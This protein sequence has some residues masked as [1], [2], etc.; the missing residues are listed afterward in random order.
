ME[1]IIAIVVVVLGVA[2]YFNRK[3]TESTDPVETWT[4]PKELHVTAEPAP[5]PAPAPAPVVEAEV[6]AP[7]KKTAAKK[8]TVKAA[9]VKKP[10]PAKK[11]PAKTPAKK[12]KK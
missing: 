5:A 3:K 10:A 6:A 1:L 9:A 12:P 7:A 11:T 8:T 2:L 4:P